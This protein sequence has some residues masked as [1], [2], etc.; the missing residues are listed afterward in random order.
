MEPH[1]DGCNRQR[2]AGVGPAGHA[3]AERLPI[4]AARPRWKI[5]APMP[6]D[7]LDVVTRFVLPPILGG[8]GGLSARP[9]R[10]YPQPIHSKSTVSKSRIGAVQ[11]RLAAH[12]F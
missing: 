4:R 8:A 7:L 9:A 3:S 11:Q 6:L 10:S 2:Q 12:E 5:R 1:P